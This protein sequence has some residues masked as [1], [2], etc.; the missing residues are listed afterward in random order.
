MNITGEKRAI[1]EIKRSVDF[2]E[3]SAK[4]AYAKRLRTEERICLKHKANQEK[5]L[6]WHRKQARPEKGKGKP[7]IQQKR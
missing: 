6:E 4:Q 7:Y 3:K 2:W 5:V 1:E